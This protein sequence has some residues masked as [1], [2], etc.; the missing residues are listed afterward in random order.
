VRIAD[1]LTRAR[2]TT[3]PGPRRTRPEAVALAV[4]GVLLAAAFAAEPLGWWGGDVHQWL[5]PLSA[6]FDP[7]LGPGLPLAVA[8][9]VAGVRWGPELA[10]TLRWRSLLVLTW[11]PACCGASGW[12]CCAA[13][14][15][16][17]SP[18]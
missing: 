18:R 9:A 14:A 4:A 3:R 5:P 10:Q 1:H 8:V 11:A 15:A 2:R 17:S 7:A 6:H 13:G 12:P 16:A